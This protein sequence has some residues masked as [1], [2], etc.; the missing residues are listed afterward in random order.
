MGA[1][2][3]APAPMPRH[4]CTTAVEQPRALSYWVETV[5]DQFLDL[6]IDTPIRDRFAASLDQVDFGPVTANFFASDIQRVRR[7]PAKIAR[8]RDPMFILMQLRSGHV[9]VQQLG[10]DVHLGPGECVFLDGTEPYDLQCPQPTKALALRLPARW[11]RSWLA[12]PERYTG[13]A[14]TAGGWSSA[15]CAAVASLDVDSC[16]QL[17]VSRDAIADPIAT[18]LKLAIG[19][20]ARA[21]TQQPLLIDR[22]TRS[23][24]SRFHETDLSPQAVAAENHIS[25]R[26]LHYAFASARTTFIERL[27]G[28]RL[29]RAR[30][31][32]SDPH[33]SD[34][35]VA[36][37][38]ARC[39]FADPSHFARRFRRQFGQSPVQ[40]RS[41]TVH[42]RH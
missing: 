34:L 33:L 2:L 3:E 16:D 7:T 17:A 22:L 32:L 36:E 18:L 11:L 37:V 12:Q 26:S 5:C 24:Q 41:S 28:L 39:G 29:E 21:A 20:D 14:F 13:R 6:E 25:T 23:L 35:P 10:H 15:L 38:A 9:R 40:F 30:Q 4:W 27:M 42:G 19:P 8:L 31:M 1:R